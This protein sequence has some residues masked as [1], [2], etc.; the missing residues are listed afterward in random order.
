MNAVA[1]TVLCDPQGFVTVPSRAAYIVRQ[2]VAER[3]ALG[4][5]YADRSFFLDDEDTP[6][7]RLATRGGFW[8]ATDPTRAAEG[9][10]LSDVTALRSALLA[11]GHRV[12]RDDADAMLCACERGALRSTWEAKDRTGRDP[13]APDVREAMLER[14]R[15]RANVRRGV[16]R[17]NGFCIVC[18]RTATENGNATCTACQRSANAR[19]V[20]RRK[21][22]V[23]QNRARAIRAQR[24]DGAP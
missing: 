18:C 19:L 20:G 22:R 6:E 10:S 5:A 11:I 13:D 14:K 2:V 23:K 12:S 16:A 24:K 7:R 8:N 15:D 4:T 17:A 3:K 9:F 1:L 21:A